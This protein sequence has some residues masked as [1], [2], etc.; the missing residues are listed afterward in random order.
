MADSTEER[1]FPGVGDKAPLFDLPGTGGR[2]YRLE[3][4]RGH[5]TVLVFYPA[6]HTPVCTQQLRSYDE[7]LSQFAALDATVWGL[8]P[9][10]VESHEEFAADIGVKLPLLADEDKQVGESY[11]IL[12][13]LG[14]YRRSVFVLDGSGTVRFV[15][16]SLT[17]MTYVPADR[18]IAAVQ[19]DVSPS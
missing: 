16:R 15:R 17:N 11:G 2:R 4:E 5:P 9:Q 10:G 1:A 8:S 14:F 18:L 7:D 3:E 12:G 19:G 6:D 13:P